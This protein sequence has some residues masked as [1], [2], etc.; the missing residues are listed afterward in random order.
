MLL[1]TL[2]NVAEKVTGCHL[3]EARLFGMLS[4]FYAS[5]LPLSAVCR[6]T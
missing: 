4:W 2:A 5:T 3:P 1:P 6:S